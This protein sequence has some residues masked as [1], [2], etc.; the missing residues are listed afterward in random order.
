MYGLVVMYL[1][2]GEIVA[3]AMT[4]NKGLNEI[5]KGAQPTRRWVLYVVAGFVV[6]VW[7]AALFWLLI[8]N[9]S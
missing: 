8:E 7:P 4:G 3:L 5:M 2:A 6:V 1:I 9:R